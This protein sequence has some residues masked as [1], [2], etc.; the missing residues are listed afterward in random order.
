[1]STPKCM[2]LFIS[3]VLCFI[4]KVMTFSNS[5][6]DYSHFPGEQIP[7]LAGPITSTKN[8]IPFNFYHLDICKPKKIEKEEDSLGEILTGKEMYK[9]SYE[10]FINKNEFCKTF[11][12]EEFS[13]SKVKTLEWVLKKKY[14][15]NWYVDK[16]PAGLFSY[17]IITNISTI[18][19]LGGI[20][21]GFPV[22]NANNNK[23]TYNIYNHFQFRI[24]VHPTLEGK[25]E[26]VG[27]NILPFSIKQSESSSCAKSMDT[28]TDNFKVEQQE[29]VEGNIM[30]TYDIIFEKSNL[31]L[32]T[33]WDFYQS[34]NQKIHLAGVILSNGIIII[35]TA[36]VICI[37]YRAVYKDIQSY[38]TKVSD[39]NFIDE[40]GWKQ[41]CNDVFRPCYN[42]VFL[43]VLVGTGIQLFCMLFL[44]L[45]LATLGFLRPEQRTNIFTLGLLLFV[46][47]G[48][49]AGYATTRVLK[50]LR[51][52][53]WLKTSLIT[54]FF[55]PGTTFLAYNIMNIILVIEKS[56][57]TAKFF[58]IVTLAVLWLFC[59]TPLVLIGAFFGIKRKAVKIPCKINPVPTCISQKPW[60]MQFKVTFWIAGTISFSTI[61]I[62]FAYIM[63]SLW[64]E[65]FFFVAT[66]LWIAILILVIV[67]SEI[68]I[69]LVYFNLCKGDYNWW[70]KSFC[71][72]GSSAAYIAIYSVYYFFSLNITRL[73]AII[74]YFEVMFMISAMSFLVCGSISTIITFVFLKKIYSMIK[75]D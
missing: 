50:I 3:I 62:E 57:A 11:C 70:W 74:V 69:I 36:F 27:F 38:N 73:S 58:D 1:M 17:N 21:I 28:I 53:H 20:P 75:I 49:P 30:F 25:Y 18:E 24:L 63:A 45:F 33:R 46:F 37:F 61:F 71:F 55:I 23:T 2:S 22:V 13:K 59:S 48:I 47:M 64:K 34:D 54:A 39:A 65:Q 8:P 35:L 44:T 32:V 31:T 26:V 52:Q 40:S 12:I 42:P 56:S 41:V 7:I 43:S 72:G 51:G 68:S 4:S 60:Y 9:T 10:A 6:L 5:V 29:L 14:V 19:H 16:L 66:F 15:S 67:S